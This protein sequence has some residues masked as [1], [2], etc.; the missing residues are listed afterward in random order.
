ML[1]AGFVA[2]FGIGLAEVAE[3]S[4]EA[5]ALQELLGIA[6]GVSTGG[7][8]FLQFARLLRLGVPNMSWSDVSMRYRSAKY[9]ESQATALAMYD[10][11]VVMDPTLAQTARRRL[12]DMDTSRRFQYQVEISFT[13]PSTGSIETVYRSIE[14]SYAMSASEVIGTLQDHIEA[15]EEP[16]SPGDKSIMSMS[17]PE[18]SYR[19]VRFYRYSYEL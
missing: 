14:S 2:A 9:W 3:T 7:G 18:S 15:K 10:P 19:V 16:T 6:K 13:N 4:V 5:V 1:P 12:S 11:S 8:V 17:L